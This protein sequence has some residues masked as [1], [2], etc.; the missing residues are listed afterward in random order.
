MQIEIE[1]ENGFT[2]ITDGVLAKLMQIEGQ[3]MAEGHAITDRGPMQHGETYVGYRLDPRTIQLV[4]GV[5]G[6][7]WTEIEAK[8][9]TLMRLLRFR[10]G[11]YHVRFTTDAGY[12]RLINCCYGGGM[13]LGRE[14]GAT[15]TKIGLALYAP[16]PTFYDEAGDSICF[17]L[18]GG[19]TGWAIPW[20]IPWTL[21]M[22]TLSQTVTI[23]Y[24]G[25][26][27][28][29]PFIHIIGPIT[30]CEITN[31]VTGDTL[32]FD[33]VT[34]AAAHYYDIDCAY[35]VKTV[36]DNHGTNK[37]ADLSYVSDLASFHLAAAPE[38]PGG[39]NSITVTGTSITA[40][41]QIYMSYHTRFVGI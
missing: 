19:G 37:I 8:T 40:A 12:V 25:S 31:N 24:S 21:G 39:N 4:L 9:D 15:F 30:D 23:P 7:T 35:G 38:A 41:T 22:S 36:T 6:A 20:V 26:F 13:T 10:D 33:G 1:W 3:G 16:D 5:W 2:S 14:P 11:L 17:S 32:D 28:A 34:I 18:A 27:K 29:Y